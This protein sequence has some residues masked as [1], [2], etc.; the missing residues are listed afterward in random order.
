MTLAHTFL[1]K[2]QVGIFQSQACKYKKDAN[3][4]KL[5]ISF[6]INW[7]WWCWWWER[8][9]GADGIRRISDEFLI[10]QELNLAVD[11]I[12]FQQRIEMALAEA[13]K[14]ARHIEV[15]F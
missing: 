12:F 15:V 6:Y 3:N 10:F 9:E 11:S 5:N 7:I 13:G 2:S 8:D 1:L 14:L 4:K